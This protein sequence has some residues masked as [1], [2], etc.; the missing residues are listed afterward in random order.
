[1]TRMWHA[2]EELFQKTNRQPLDQ[3]RTNPSLELDEYS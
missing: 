1:M 2:R 3:P